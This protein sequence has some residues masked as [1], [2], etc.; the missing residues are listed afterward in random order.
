MIN[1]LA[2]TNVLASIQLHLFTKYFACFSII[3]VIHIN[4]ELRSIFL[5]TAHFVIA[6]IFLSLCEESSQ[7]ISLFNRF[8]KFRVCISNSGLRINFH[9]ARP[10]AGLKDHLVILCREAGSIRSVC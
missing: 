8:T 5:V 1:D 4:I 6:L 9:G 2:E 10:R 7:Q 3:G